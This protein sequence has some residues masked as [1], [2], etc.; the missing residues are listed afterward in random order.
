MGAIP[1]KGS[2]DA[3]IGL[4]R[5]DIA[6]GVKTLPAV[7]AHLK[8]GKPR[9]LAVTGGKRTAFLPDTPG[10]EGLNLSQASFEAFYAVAAPGRTPPAVIQRL[11][12]EI[13]E[14]MALP[15][16]K[17]KC[18]QLPLEA[19]S[20]EADVG[21]FRDLGRRVKIELDQPRT[22]G[23]PARPEVHLGSNEGASTTRA[24]GSGSTR[25]GRVWG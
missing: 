3:V 7:A 14:I 17:E 10:M 11:T 2:A 13:G 4:V 1:H 22:P 23:C 15:E 25:R 21:R 12:R 6:L 18:A 20:V 19:V 5:G 16:V 9:A 24:S 8:S